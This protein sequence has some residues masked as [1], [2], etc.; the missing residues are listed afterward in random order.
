MQSNP[1][2]APQRIGV[3]RKT[4]PAKRVAAVP[5]VMEKLVKLGF[6]VTTEPGAGDAAN[7]S[8]DA[9]RTAWAASVIVFRVRSPAVTRWR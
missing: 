9:Y 4:F 2:T 5:D 8:D 3:P 1:S 7:F 6:T